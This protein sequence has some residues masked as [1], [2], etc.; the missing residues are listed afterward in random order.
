MTNSK[1]TVSQKI[2]ATIIFMITSA[3]MNHFFIIYFIVKFRKDLLKRRNITTTASQIC[4]RTTLRNVR[5]QL[6]NFTFILARIIC[7]MSS[8]ISFTSF[9]L[10][11]YFRS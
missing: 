2:R 9:H 4:C 8:D 10:F 11:I 1:Y 5:V 7:F 3:N 6:Y